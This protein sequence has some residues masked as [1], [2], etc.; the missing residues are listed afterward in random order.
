[1]F[2]KRT[3]RK[4]KQWPDTKVYCCQQ[5]GIGTAAL[6]S[7]PVTL[8]PLCFIGFVLHVLN[9][10][11]YAWSLS[12]DPFPSPMLIADE[13]YNQYHGPWVPSV[14]F[15]PSLRC[16]FRL[17]W[18]LTK[19][20]NLWDCFIW[21]TYISESWPSGPVN[22]T[23][24]EILVITL[25]LAVDEASGLSP[26]FRSDTNNDLSSRSFTFIISPSHWP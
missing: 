21:C 4:V 5:R 18:V 9:T 15:K 13:Y 19:I 26:P 10:E 23:G 22:A 2:T 17:F 16:V 7:L 25:Y 24:L 1:M 11:I 20:I 8:L 14:S 6:S 3:Q 12:T